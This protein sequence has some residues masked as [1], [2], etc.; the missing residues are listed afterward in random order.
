MRGWRRSVPAARTAWGVP[1]RTQNQRLG[2]GTP[3]SASVGALTPT[4]RKKLRKEGFER[5]TLGSHKWSMGARARTIR[6]MHPFLFL[7]LP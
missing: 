2:R 7:S 5:Q 4:D 1:A 6:L 3:K